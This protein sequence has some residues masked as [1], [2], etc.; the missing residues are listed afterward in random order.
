MTAR[1][2]IVD[3]ILA[4]VKL[5]EARL[6]AEYFQ[7]ST[8]FSGREALEV[9]KSEHVDVVLLDV[10]MPGMDGFE[11]CRRI[12][13]DPAIMHVPVVMVTALD[14]PSDKIQG[15]KAGA[16]D[17]LSKPIDEIALVT[18]VRNLARF[19]TLNDEMLRR[20]SS[21]AE[22]GLPRPVLLPWTLVEDAG[23]RVL[24][25]E[26][27]ER[28]VQRVVAALAKAHSVDVESD[29]QTALAGLGHKAYDL[30]IVS[31]S[32][33]GADG[34]RLCSQIRS[35]EKV[36]ELPI[37]AVAERSQEGRLLR[38]LDMG[39]NDYLLRQRLYRAPDRRQR[40]L[41]KGAHPGQA[42]APLRSAAHKPGR[43][44][45]ACHHGS[46]D[47]PVQQALPGGQHPQACPAGEGLGCA[48]FAAAGGHRPLQVGQ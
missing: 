11:V 44:C 10:M 22:F 31:L 25:V 12:K 45:R 5:L 6:S 13:Q 38:A 46:S 15:L 27:D 39:I 16:D 32:L 43:Q 1:I 36:R 40:A 28:A 34:L 2:L 19:K 26:D 48:A 20:V 42:Q 29:V 33:K 23:A 30:M 47:R 24:L 17:F 7:V 37:I 41:G 21:S 14:Q 35:L 3:D 4:N 18:R 8:A 9:L